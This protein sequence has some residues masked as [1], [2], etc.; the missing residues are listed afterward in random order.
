MQNICATEKI[1]E[2]KNEKSIAVL[3]R[4]ALRWSQDSVSSPFSPFRH[5]ST[6]S[7]SSGGSIESGE[8]ALLTRSV[9]STS[10]NPDSLIARQ[11]LELLV[12]CLQ[13]R[14]SHIGKDRAVELRLE[15]RPRSFRHWT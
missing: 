13:L 11:A 10:K 12:A 5:T 14:P 3:F 1:S 4:S 6:S 7:V 8:R 2:K 15:K 9:E